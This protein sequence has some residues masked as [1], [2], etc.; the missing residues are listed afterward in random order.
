M[1]LLINEY[2]LSFKKRNDPKDN[3]KIGVRKDCITITKS[4]RDLE[5]GME[6]WT[7]SL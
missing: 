2:R 4:P 7:I 3:S 6:D 5:T 1:E